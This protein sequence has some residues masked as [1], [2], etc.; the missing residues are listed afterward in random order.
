MTHRLHKFMADKA[1]AKLIL[2]VAIPLMLQQLI[3]S[4]VNLI[5]NLMVGQLGDFSIGGVAAVNRFYIIA[6]YGTNGV[7]AACA[8]FLAQFYGANNKTKMQ[9]TFRFAVII[10][11]VFGLVFFSIA[12]LFPT[13]IVSYFTPDPGIIDVGV[14]Y[15]QIAAYTYIP[16]AISLA[17][18]CSLRSVG[19]TKTPMYISA[20][21][22]LIN[23]ILNYCLIFGHFGF[24]KLGVEGAAIATLIARIVEVILY[25]YVIVRND[26]PFVSPFKKMLKIPWNLSKRILVKALPLG[27]NEVM[28]SFGIATLFKFYSTRGIEVMSGYSIATTISDIFFVLFAGMAAATTVLISQPLG[29]NKLDEARSNAYRI[30]GFSFLLSIV[31]GIM[32]FGASFI[33]PHFYNVS[34]EAKDSSVMFLRIMSLLFWIYMSNAQCYFILRAGGDTRSTLFMDAGFMWLVNLPIVGFITYFTD[35]NVII[36]YVIGQ[37]TDFLKLAIAYR[38]VSKEK[39]VNNLAHHHD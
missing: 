7:L 18:G 34:M 25:I 24:P 13:Q 5:D 17:I 15:I 3:T 21:A 29:A 30:M 36:L 12:L 37:S 23:T 2:A 35:F 6:T 26:Y 16:L 20:I 28:W 31:F 14:R 1:F 19:K 33:A 32:M 10:S 38:L 39:W 4:S 11:L 22:V 8:I 9:E 27:L